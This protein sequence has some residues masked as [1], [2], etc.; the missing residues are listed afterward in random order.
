MAEQLHRA[1]IEVR[2]ETVA[3]LHPVRGGRTHSPLAVETASGTL[4]FGSVIVATGTSPVSDHG[5]LVGRTAASRVF[6][7][8]RDVRAVRGSR[9][10]VVG[11]GDAAFDYALGL[12][13]ANDVAVFVRTDEARCIPVLL[14][15]ARTADGLTISWSTS[16]LAIERGTGE[17]LSLAC[18]YRGSPSSFPCDYAIIAVGREPALA[19]VVPA[20]RRGRETVLM[21]GDVVSGAQRQASIAVGQGVMAAM[22]LAERHRTWGPDQAQE[23][24]G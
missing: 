2:A 1:R 20:L 10:A 23:T 22:Q 15:R 11:G 4:E 3:S 13:E 12:S 5:V 24:A 19:F 14:Q 8:G 7:S 21:A 18:D 16:V 9:I 17:S 6:R